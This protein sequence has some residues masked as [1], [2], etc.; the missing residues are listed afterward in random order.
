MV[1]K[2]VFE[3]TVPPSLSFAFR[4]SLLPASVRVQTRKVSLRSRISPM[5]LMFETSET[6]PLWTPRPARSFL[7]WKDFL[8]ELDGSLISA[9]LGCPNGPSFVSLTW[10]SS[11][12]SHLISGSCPVKIQADG[13]LGRALKETKPEVGRL[14]RGPRGDCVWR[15]LNW[16]SFLGSLEVTG[17]IDWGSKPRAFFELGVLQTSLQ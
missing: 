15:F 3:E 16:M 9:R 11:L 1:E 13:C 12:L 10:G 7:P 8:L 6:C 14:S 5:Q 17:H 2:T 4:P